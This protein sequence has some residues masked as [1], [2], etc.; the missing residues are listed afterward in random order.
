[1]ES[2]G[3]GRRH[4]DK[5]P[6]VLSAIEEANR[7]YLSHLR[8]QA[9]VR[10]VLPRQEVQTVQGRLKESGGKA[11][12][13]LTGEAGVG[14]SG[15]MLQVVE[16]LIGAG[17]PVVAFRA[18]RLEPTQLPDSVGGQIGLPGSPANVLAAVAQGRHCVLVI[19]QLD[20]LSLA[21]GRNA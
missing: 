17:T 2:R 13:L 10:T 8:G 11:G 9:I 6:H 1:M 14:K 5:D 15:V 21:S 16:E 19:D 7:R 12:V 20:A 3:F 18:D 4:W